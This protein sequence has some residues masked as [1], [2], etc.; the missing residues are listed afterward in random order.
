MSSSVRSVVRPDGR[1]LVRPHGRWSP[2]AAAEAVGI[3]SELG[4][5]ALAHLDA[6]AHD[7][8][9]ILARAGFT[10][11]RTEAR[12]VVDVAGALAMLRD[13]EVPAGVALRSAA[14]VDE[15]HLRLLDDEL[16]AD[17]PG[18][19]GWRSTAEEFRANTFEDPAFD[20]TTYLV[21]T[22]DAS[23]EHLGLVRV[24]MNRGRPRLGLV[25]VR[26]G[27]RRRGIASAL[28]RRSFEA[29]RAAGEREVEA[30][31]DVDHEGS[32]ALAAR[33]GARRFGTTI[34]LLYEPGLESRPEAGVAEGVQ[35]VR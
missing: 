17:V 9:V 3:A 16:R 12:V 1:C 21:A 24:W 31:Y 30:G 4:L 27:H 19:S 22:A 5:P 23:G 25:G 32:R 15:G 26:R 28:L 11:S 29:V 6:D 10:D 8:Y 14:D 2:R 18:T 33:L 20:G 35:R 7:E 13:A 34:E